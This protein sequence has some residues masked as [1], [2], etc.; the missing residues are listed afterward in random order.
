MTMALLSHLRL[1]GS[2]VGTA[3][4]AQDLTSMGQRNINTSLVPLYSLITRRLELLSIGGRGGLLFDWLFCPPPLDPPVC[5]PKHVSMKRA[6]KII[7][8]RQ[9]VTL[10][11]ALFLSR[12]RS[13]LLRGNPALQGRTG[14]LDELSVP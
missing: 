1:Y 14:R 11:Q 3:S 10:Y 6:K 4:Q 7:E 5:M 2:K 9:I 8:F 13:V 12:P